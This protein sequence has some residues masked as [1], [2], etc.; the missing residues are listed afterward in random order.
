MGIGLEYVR[1]ST[2]GYYTISL[3]REGTFERMA[4]GGTATLTIGGFETFTVTLPT[5]S[6]PF[7]I[8]MTDGGY[9][10]IDGCYVTSADGIR[11]DVGADYYYGWPAVNGAVTDGGAYENPARLYTAPA[12]PD[13]APAAPAALVI[14]GMPSPAVWTVQTVDPALYTVSYRNALGD[15]DWQAA[16]RPDASTVDLSATYNQPGSYH[17]LFRVTDLATGLV[18]AETAT[19]F[20][21]AS[22]LPPIPTPQITG[23]GVPPTL[24]YVTD[25]G[26]EF[27]LEYR[28]SAADPSA[29]PVVASYD[30]LTGV[31]DLTA[32][33]PL[34]GTYEVLFAWRRVADGT[35]GLTA[36]VM[37][38]VVDDTATEPLPTSPEPTYPAPGDRPCFATIAELEDY[39]GRAAPPGAQRLLHRATEA[40]AALVITPGWSTN[41]LP[42]TA[43]YAAACRDAVCAFVEQWEEVGEDNDIASRTPGSTVKA[44]KVSYEVGSPVPRRAVRALH[45]GGLMRLGG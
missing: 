7:R 36:P 1:S 16:P 8:A 24:V 32:A 31:A 26:V 27:V 25:A 6:L 37:F 21:I 45:R 28:D 44:G 39:L 3:Y 23:N 18:S 40:V 4:P 38:S 34:V 22:P 13:P 12:E 11:E 14:T 2:S 30:R 42:N 20:D 33:F 35:S 9:Y 43:A 5:D 41:D 10:R 29:G 17:L 15:A 19:T